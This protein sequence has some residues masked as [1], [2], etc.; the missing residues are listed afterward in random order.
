VNWFERGAE[1]NAQ[2]G[3]FGSTFNAV[4]C[5]GLLIFGLIFGVTREP[6]GFLFA[7]V[8]AGMDI[9]F[10]WGAVKAWRR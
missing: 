7:L 1:R 9:V 2:F 6:V 5:S 8:A 10:V 4:F 3:K